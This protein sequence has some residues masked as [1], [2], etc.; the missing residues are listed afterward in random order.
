VV[1]KTTYDHLGPSG[2]E[3]ALNHAELRWTQSASAI[4]PYP[5][6]SYEKL[7]GELN[8]EIFFNRTGNPYAGS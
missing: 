6:A 3:R 4:Y 8:Y 7:T 2:I 5:I 1:L